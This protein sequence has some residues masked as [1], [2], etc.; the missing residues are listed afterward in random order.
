M[1]TESK[2]F[3]YLVPW[4]LLID[5]IYALWSGFEPVGSLGILLLAGMALMIGGYFVVLRRRIDARPEDN[6]DGLVEQGA[7]DQG[8]FS[9][10][11]WWPLAIGAAAATVFLGL[12]VGWW[13]VY[14][15]SA[16]GMVALV[17]LIF[18]FSRGQHAH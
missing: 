16:L 3:L 5:V 4:F 17:G 14:V 15:G 10:W 11:S 6:P 9:P 1:R 12:A 18:E 8:V 13:L 2:T 7:G